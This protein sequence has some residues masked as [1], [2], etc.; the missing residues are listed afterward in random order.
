MK[1]FLTIFERIATVYKWNEDIWSLK[2]APLLIGPAQAAN[3]N[4][5][6]EDVFEYQQVKAAILKRYDIN[7]ETYRQR[8]REARPKQNESHGEF[9]LRIRDLFTK[10]TH[11][12]TC[13]VNE[14]ADTL[15]LEHFLNTLPNMLQVWVREKKP[16]TP[17]VAAEF[18]DNYYLARKAI[19][20]E[21]SK[22]RSS[23]LNAIDISHVTVLQNYNKT[24]NFRPFN[25]EQ[26]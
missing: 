13:K 22:S 12:D 19:P 15:I 20:T 8:F 24:H 26:C 17:T 16:T 10:G 4:I 3:A 23:V 2:L 21:E 9:V 1:F 25:Q 5:A 6:K 11:L 14:L 7:E 18:S